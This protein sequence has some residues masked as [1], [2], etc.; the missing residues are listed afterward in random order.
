V[1]SGEAQSTGALGSTTYQLNA[2][3]QRIRKT[4]STLGDSVFHYDAHGRLIAET[5]ANGSFKREF[6][7]LGDIPVY[8]VQ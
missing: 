7:Y 8:V 6:V 5:G 2:L 3:G 1:K 4:N